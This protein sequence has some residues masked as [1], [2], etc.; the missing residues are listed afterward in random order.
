MAQDPFHFDLNDPKDPL[1]FGFYKVQ[2]ALEQLCDTVIPVVTATAKRLV[3]IF[4]PV[5]NAVLEYQ[6][7][8]DL[9]AEI[10]PHIAYLAFHAKK[11]RVREKNLKRLYRLG[12]RSDNHYN[13]R[14]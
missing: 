6:K 12:K 11:K 10:N 2:L 9:G 13:Q 5:A 8:I 14:D 7:A 1:Q 4:T 3:D